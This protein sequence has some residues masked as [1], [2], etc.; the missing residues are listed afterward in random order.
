MSDLPTLEQRWSIASISLEKFGMDVSKVKH[1]LHQA[2]LLS[3]LEADEIIGAD[4]DEWRD[5]VNAE[6]EEHP[7][8]ALPRWHRLVHSRHLIEN[9]HEGWGDPG[10]DPEPEELA[11]HKYALLTWHRGSSLVRSAGDTM[12]SVLE[13]ICMIQYSEEDPESVESFIDL[14]TGE[15]TRLYGD[16]AKPSLQTTVTLT[17]DKHTYTHHFSS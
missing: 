5:W 10:S 13:T 15:P 16:P 9:W 11:E 4:D 3:R 8:L 7:A 6:L 2:T 14:D 17:Y 12:E 1:T